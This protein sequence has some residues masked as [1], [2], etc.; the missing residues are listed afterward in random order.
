MLFGDAR[1]I[2]P[3]E[4]AAARAF[5]LAALMNSCLEDSGA[6]KQS[7]IDAKAVPCLLAALSNGT[8]LAPIRVRAAGLLSRLATDGGAAGSLRQLKAVEQLTK[9]LKLNARGGEGGED[10][11]WVEEERDHLVR[12]LALLVSSHASQAAE[13]L[14][15]TSKAKA[16]MQD[17]E[18]LEYLRLE[19][20]LDA[21]VTF[22][23]PA[24]ADGRGDVTASSVVQ[25]VPDNKKVHFKLSGNV[26]K[27][28]IPGKSSRHQS[29][30]HSPNP[31]PASPAKPATLDPPPRGCYRL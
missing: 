5:A 19:G 25:P 4:T 12:L 21:L 27:C 20:V 8:L 23:P 7:L 26:V 1:L 22:L 15:G 9:A 11:K 6:V 18:L 13:A 10:G 17:T 2:L 16:G 3:G 24:T 29:L 31:S 14:A 28:F 30:L